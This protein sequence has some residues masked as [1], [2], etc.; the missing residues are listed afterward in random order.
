MCVRCGRT[1]DGQQQLT[2]RDA[3]S[4]VP[5]RLGVEV[6]GAGAEQEAAARVVGGDQRFHFNEQNPPTLP[7]VASL[8]TIRAILSHCPQAPLVQ[9][10]NSLSQNTELW[11]CAHLV[12]R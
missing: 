8:D 2:P 12:I 10:I 5:V 6:R 7:I 3:G 11:E 1:L 4:P 9:E